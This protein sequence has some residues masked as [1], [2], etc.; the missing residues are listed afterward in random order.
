MTAYCT[1]EAEG[2][3]LALAL[4]FRTD[5]YSPCGKQLENP[6]KSTDALAPQPSIVT[7]GNSSCAADVITYEQHVP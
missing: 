5:G 1:E 6:S 3:R 2:N 7:H 4:L